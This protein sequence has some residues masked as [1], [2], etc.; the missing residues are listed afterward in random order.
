MERFIERHRDRV[1]GVLSG[2]DRVLFRGTLR[3]ISY[4]NGMCTF[5]HSHGILY[6][7]FGPFAQRLSDRIKSRA[8]EI[9]ATQGRPYHYLYSSSVRK[10]DIARQIAEADKIQEGLICILSAVE[11]CMSYQVRRD[12]ELKQLVVTPHERK[13][14]HLY[15]Y[16]VDREFGFMHVRL[17]TWVPFTIQVC[18]NGREWLANRM[19]R[20][21][22]KFTRRENCFTAIEDLPAAQKLMD[23][24]ATR[25]WARVL[26]ALARPV[27]PWIN[28]KAGLDLNGYYWSIREGEYATD[29]MFRDAEALRAV[30]PRLVDHAIQ[31]F[32]C[33]DVLRFLGRRT[34]CVF[35]GEVQSNLRRRP[36]G[37]RVKH[38]VEENSIKMYDKQGSVLRIETT[39]NNP[40]RFKVR[41]RATRKGKSTWAWI[42]MRKGIADIPRRVELSRAANERYLEAL[43]VVGEASPTHRLL[44]PVSRRVI[45]NDRPYRALRPI[46]P[47]DATL[48]RAVLR[49]E[50][51]IRGF[52]SKEL[53]RQLLPESE[54][55]PAQRKR[56]SGRI[57]RWIRL[58]RAH[59]L[60]RK[61]SNTRYYR[62]TEKGQ[63]LMTTALRLRETNADKLVA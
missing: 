42:P 17:Q 37:I 59:G 12:R 63:T 48:F 60:V 50:F 57:T 54:R 35:P 3:S 51:L 8:E 2:F 26:N 34:N 4:L 36:E 32:T 6:K 62:V 16:Y 21:G 41:R 45:K 31:E 7:D 46:S 44:D 22:I 1:I 5:L 25:S 61:V 39:I 56:A 47:P 38:V 11:P 55:D 40:R 23:S 27:N 18:I 52:T 43:A 24:L 13:C 20:T 28:P 29:V 15:F 30:Y 33:E 14:L 58:L 53:R 19:Q 49:G 10:E 9:A